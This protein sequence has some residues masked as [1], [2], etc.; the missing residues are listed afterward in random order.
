MQSKKLD[1]TYND[2]L[3]EYIAN[4]QQISKEQYCDYEK[5]KYKYKPK[6]NI[7]ALNYIHNTTET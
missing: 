5:S 4:H 7:T 1:Q 2:Y 3:N 6:T